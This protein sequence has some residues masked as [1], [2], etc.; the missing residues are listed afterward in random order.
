MRTSF[1]RRRGRLVWSGCF[2]AVMLSAVLALAVQGPCGAEEASIYE[3]DLAAFFQEVDNTYPFFD[4]KGVRDDWTAAKE[5]LSERVKGCGSDTEF[6]GIVIEAI[7]CLR[8]SHM[9]IR[10]A[11]AEPP[12]RPKRYYPGVSFMPAVNNRVVVMRRSDGYGEALKTGT[13]VTKIGGEDARRHL[14]NRAREAWPTSFCSSPQ[15]ARLH[16]FRTPLRTEKAGET[17]TITYLAEGEEHE[18]VL[19]CNVEARGWPHVYNLPADLTRV[20]RSFYFTK[21]PSGVGYMWLRHVDGSTESG[22]AQALE[23]FPDT[24]GWVVDLCGNGGGGYGSSLIEKLQALPRPVAVI[25]DAGCFSAGETLARDLARCADA[26]LFGSRTAG[27]S[28]AKRTWTFPSG[29]TSVTFSRRSRWRNDGQPIEFNGIEPHEKVEAVPEEVAKGLNSAICRA[30][31]YLT[32]EYAKSA[33]N[34]EAP[35]GGEE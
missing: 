23:T 17:H 13:V 30:E 12:P 24:H 15:R 10:D 16:E 19:T 11:K 3:T 27:A 25:I 35:P 7:G 32:K 9:W 34:D 2:P 8:D 28:S 22:M 31:E 18:L 20:G 33:A 1:R 4:L 14:E 29:I 26:R 6:L 21:L 5:R